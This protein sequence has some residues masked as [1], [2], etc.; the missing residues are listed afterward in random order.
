MAVSPTTPEVSTSQGSWLSRFFNPALRGSSHRIEFIAGLTTF[1]TM[2]YIIF[3][4]EQILSVTGLDPVAL[5]IGTIL[6]AAIPTLIMGFWADLPWALA[7][8]MGYNALFAFTVVSQNHFPVKAALA[9]VFL[10]GLM[11]TIVVAGPWRSR[12][13]TGIPLN[14]KLAAGAGIGLFIAY[15][16]LINSGVVVLSGSGP[17][18][19]S[20]N[21]ASVT[22]AFI[23]LVLTIA[24]L[25]FRV[26]GALLI[27]ILGTSVISY[28]VGKFNTGAGAQLGVSALP[29]QLNGYIASPDF[30]RFFAKGAFQMDFGA[31]FN[32]NI[33]ASA[34]ILF[35]LTFLITDMMDSL[36]TFSGL[37]TK[38]GILDEKGN[39]P[40]FG[41]AFF[42]DAASGMW[43]AITGNST[44]ATFIESSSGVSEGGKT[45]IASVWTAFFFLLALFFV[46]L[47]GLV[48]TVATTPALVV[49]GYYMIEPIVKVNFS[50]PTDAIPAFLAL[51][52][53]P[54]TYSIA[55]GMFVGIVS[56][57]VLKLVTGKV[58]DISVTM[59]IFG[60]LLLA[61]QILNAVVG[62]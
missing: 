44:I 42:I 9:L 3:V 49:V 10:D 58:K 29:T 51:L 53:M 60:I 1:V 59:W 21:S 13:I 30:G 36:G 2:S 18:L 47:V 39:F 48:P 43:G 55:N 11:F 17:A 28:V 31:L 4:N 27:S 8:G 23:G 41:K 54:L 24:L 50:D 6:S 45:G 22:V 14:L 32:G 38:L 25:A 33:A 35:F 12:I 46:P 16:G 19:G 52:F 34:I 62:I 26:R 57:V 20:F 5:T 37:A 15:I 61:S 56:Y 40:G 7:P